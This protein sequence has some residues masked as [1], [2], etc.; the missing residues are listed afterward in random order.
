MLD[1]QSYAGLGK[2]I[3]KGLDFLSFLPPSVHMI[4]G[5]VV[6]GELRIDTFGIQDKLT[7]SLVGLIY[8]LCYVM[9]YS[10]VLVSGD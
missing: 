10:F 5:Y 6:Q 8:V 1:K 7:D 9:P 4:G 2:N 3:L